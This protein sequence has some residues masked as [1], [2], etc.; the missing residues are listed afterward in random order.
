MKTIIVILGVIGVI[1]TM[2]AQES[3]TTKHEITMKLNAGIITEKLSETK[4]FYTRILNFGITFENEFYLLMHPPGHQAELSFLLPD[5]PTQKPPF[6]IPFKGEGVYLTIEVD[7]VDALY[8]EIKR[9]DVEI[10]IEIRDEPWGD[11]H[12]A[13]V[14]PNGVGIDLVT[15][16]PPEKP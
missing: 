16:S 8:E 2:K 13:I 14:D 15:Y 11:R 5:H 3:S 9:K 7:D 6:R 1:A 10:K 4:E 12:F